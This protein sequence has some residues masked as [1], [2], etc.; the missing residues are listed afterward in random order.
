MAFYSQ[1]LGIALESHAYPDA[2]GRPSED[3]AARVMHSQLTAGGKPVL[4]A[5]DAPEPGS[6]Q[7]GS[8]VSISID[9]ESLDEIERLFPALSESGAVLMPLG[10]TPWGARFGMLTDRF[11][12]RWL[13][14]CFRG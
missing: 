5:S 2:T 11:G 6:V 3:P 9:C 4:M 14:N 13:L 1:C 7:V 12:V 8:N 10:D